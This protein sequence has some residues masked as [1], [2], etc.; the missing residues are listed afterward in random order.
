MIME[1]DR[2]WIAAKLSMAVVLGMAAGVVSMNVTD[3]L[4]LGSLA[5]FG[6]ITALLSMSIAAV[7]ALSFGKRM[8]GVAV[9]IMT[10]AVPV[11]ALQLKQPPPNPQEYIPA[12]L[13]YKGR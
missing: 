7:I 3:G 11:L 8:I 13:E 10:L 12:P 5:T 9:M 6:V 1:K 2:I 4:N